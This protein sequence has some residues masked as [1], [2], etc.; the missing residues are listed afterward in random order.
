MGVVSLL[1]E[2]VRPPLCHLEG[3]VCGSI[4]SIA[5]LEVKVVSILLL[6][7]P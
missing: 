6:L 7:H 5:L 2:N 4:T 1:Y 3:I